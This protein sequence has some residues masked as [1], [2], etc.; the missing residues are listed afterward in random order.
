MDGSGVIEMQ[1]LLL[2]TPNPKTLSSLSLPSPVSSGPVRTQALASWWPG[3][4]NSC[5]LARRDLVPHVTR[6]LRLIW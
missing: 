3:D 1:G 6:V 5:T 4:H 2:G